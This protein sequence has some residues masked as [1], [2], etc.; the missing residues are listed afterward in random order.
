VASRTGQLVRIKGRPPAIM[1][2]YFVSAGGV[3]GG[4]DRKRAPV[5]GVDEIHCRTDP[6]ALLRTSIHY[7][8]SEGLSRAPQQNDDQTGGARP[9]RRESVSPELLVSVQSWIMIG[10]FL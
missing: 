10:D 1:R 5:A 3:A 2:I 9:G 4:L 7:S 8:G 6:E